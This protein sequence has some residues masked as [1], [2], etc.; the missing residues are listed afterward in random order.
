MLEL[1]KKSYF[2]KESERIKKAG[3]NGSWYSLL[4]RM[5]DDD[6]PKL[7]SLADLEPDKAPEKIAEDLAEHF[8]SITNQSLPLLPSQ[9]PVY[10]VPNILVPQ[11]VQSHVAKRIRD[12]KKPNSSVPGDIPKSLINNLADKLAI[13]LTY[14]FNNCLAHTRWPKAWKREVVLA[15]PKA[16][17]PKDYNDLRPISMSPLWSKIL[18]SIVSDLTLEETKANWKANQHRGIKGSSTDHVLIESWDRIL[19]ALDKSSKNKAVVFT[20]V[21]FSKSFSRCSHH[22]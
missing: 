16:Q 21:D 4:A 15:I 14:I 20:A 11:V 6:A 17:A 1:R 7:W 8:T 19:R 10:K 12:Y 3:R 2:E 5:V 13:P 18:E 9:I 22:K